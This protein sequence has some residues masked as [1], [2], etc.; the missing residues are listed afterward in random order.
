MIPVLSD[1][2]QKTEGRWRPAAQPDRVWVVWWVSAQRRD[3]KK[4]KHG[5]QSTWAAAIRWAL[6][7]LQSCWSRL[8]APLM[9][10]EK[11]MSAVALL[12]FFQRRQSAQKS[13]QSGVQRTAPH[14]WAIGFPC[15]LKPQLHWF[16]G[17][18]DNRGGAM[19]SGTETPQLNFLP[20]LYCH[21][22]KQRLC[23]LKLTPLR[24]KSLEQTISHDKDLWVHFLLNVIH[25]CYLP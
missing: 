11:C 4:D 10:G 7:S 8:E 2:V 24:N 14:F 1:S 18:H 13:D 19:Q 3:D 9:Y 21:K 15:T 20:R 23:L 16:S 5:N 12:I 6:Q 22:H 25:H 17:C